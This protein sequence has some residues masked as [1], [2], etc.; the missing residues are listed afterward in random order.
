MFFFSV[1]IKFLENL[2]KLMDIQPSAVYYIFNA[3]QSAF[4]K[5]RHKATFL[6]GW[7]HDEL[8]PEVLESKRNILFLVDDCESSP[9]LKNIFL[10]DSHH[11]QW[12][13][14]SQTRGDWDTGC[15]WG[16]LL[17]VSFGAF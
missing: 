12:L 15:E 1:Q 13:A 11:K 17:K 7:D 9:L 4:E 2:E 16:H 14:Y 8:T 5:N 6:K 3:W 10:K